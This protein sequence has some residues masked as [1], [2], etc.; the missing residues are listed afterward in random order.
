[1]MTYRADIDGLRAIAVLAVVFYHASIAPFTGGFVG[2]DIFF[3]ISGYLISSIII[4][5][6]RHGRFSFVLFYER[7]IRRLFPALFSMIAVTTIAAVVLFL[8]VHFREYGQSLFGAAIFASNFVFW[9]EAGYFDLA[10]ETKPL[11][12][13][14]SLAVEEQF[15]IIFPL[16]LYLG[17]RYFNAR[18]PLYLAPFI[19]ASF[20]LGMA[21][22]SYWPSFTFYLLP[23]RFWELLLG[24]LLALAPPPRLR[25]RIFR[26]ALS[27]LGMG[28]IGYAIFAFSEDTPFP[29]VNA[30]APCLGAALLIYAGRD[31]HA[32]LNQILALRPIVLIGL[33]SYSLYLWHWP[34]LIF[35]EYYVVRDL[36][37]VEKWII[38]G[39]S[40]GI[41]FLSWKYVEL[42]FRG[43]QKALN[44][45][46]LFG[47]AATLTLAA[48]TS[49]LFFDISHGMPER[50]PVE[51]R[52][53]AQMRGLTHDRRDCH[54][55]AQKDSADDFCLRGAEGRAPTFMLLGDSHADM[56]GPGLFGAAEKLGRAG[57]QF[58]GTGYVPAPGY[59]R[60]GRRS[61]Y[62]KAH[63]LMD[64][65]FRANES[66]E[67]VIY[68]L[69][70]VQALDYPLYKGD[71]G[72]HAG[73]DVLT[74]ALTE[75]TR[76]YPKKKFVFLED[77]PFAQEFGP[78]SAARTDRPAMIERS[79]YEAQLDQYRNLFN[80][81]AALPNGE[82]ASIIGPLCDKEHCYGS[83]RGVLLYRDYDHLSWNGSLWLQPEFE[84]ILKRHLVRDDAPAER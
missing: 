58:T 19:V 53:I 9:E 60:G 73:E 4:A 66:I 32:V 23:T 76:R 65:V 36:A 31:G 83:R 18:W 21:T 68:T 57:I 51:T 33:I 38:I 79:V 78:E 3:V 67:L 48:I 16:M 49:G 59:E 30:L 70:W 75:L 63:Q 54:F 82:T 80:A 8:P 45:P 5:D 34:L 77:I 74:D 52:Q 17:W 20:L 81:L 10:R 15:Y 22:V 26:E 12:H 61:Q 28:L 50:I 64:D 27:I 84:K 13:T 7:R 72:W 37:N 47:A 44:R 55:A 69:F 2:V 39:A 40:F 1:M 25:W 35:S 46:Q 42:P 14:W 6:M 62:Q 29:G 71:G 43:H 11:L 41:A 56:H 24:A